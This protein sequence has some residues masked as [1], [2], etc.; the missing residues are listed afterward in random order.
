[1]VPDRTEEPEPRS[2]ELEACRVELGN[3]EAILDAVTDGIFTIDGQLRVIQFNRAA[4]EIT[5]FS[6]DEALGMPC[7]EIFRQILSGQAPAGPPGSAA[8][9]RARAMNRASKMPRTIRIQKPVPFEE[10]AGGSSMEPR[11]CRW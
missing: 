5:G 2:P 8:L 3:I 10:V 9:T 4:E 6:R 1:M 11:S 7:L